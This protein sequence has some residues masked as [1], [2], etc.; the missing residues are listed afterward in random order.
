M[1]ERAR[2]GWRERVEAGLYRVHRVGCPSSSDR[3]PGRRC[4]CPWS[5]QAPDV[6]PGSTRTV[7]LTGTLTEV[8]AARRALVAAGR[9]E[10]LAEPVEADDLRTFARRYFQASA[11]RLAPST[12]RMTADAFRLRVDPYLGTLALDEISRERLEVWLAG[13]A[14]AGASRDQRAKAVKA[15]RVI[16]AAAVEWGRLLENPA[17][18]LRLPKAPADEATAV[19]RVLTEAQ[20]AQLLTE[21]VTH[22]QS[23]RENLRV[24]TMLRAAAEAGLRKGEVIGLRWPDLDLAALRLTVAR[25]VWQ[26][27]GSDDRPSRRMVKAPKSGKPRTVAISRGYAAR[28]G[29]WFEESVIREGADAGGYVW[30]GTGGAPMGT[31]TPGQALARCLVRAGLVDDLGEPLVSF[32]GLRHTCASV[33]IAHGVPLTAVARQLGHANPNITATVYAHLLDETQ[34]DAAA[35]VFD[36]PNDAET[37]RGTM[38]GRGTEHENTSNSREDAE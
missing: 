23:G 1:S 25:S 33:M 5:V 27:A 24:E 38:R 29:E 13:L 34:L 19:R 12:V 28:L 10:A 7:T 8:R 21:G 37:M 15:L 6:E 11:A 3:K 9:P 17:R 26:E 14:T 22:K 4:G 35:A 20:L 36:A 18:R 16:L 31:G 30:P 32:H 2:R